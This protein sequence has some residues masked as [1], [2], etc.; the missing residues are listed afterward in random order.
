MSAAFQY[1]LKR[2]PF[3]RPLQSAGHRIGAKTHKRLKGDTYRVAPGAPWA[4]VQGLLSNLS[5]VM[6]PHTLNTTRRMCEL[7]CV[8]QLHFSHDSTGA[9]TN[10]EPVL[11]LIKGL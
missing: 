9:Q 5:P 1:T 4:S 6:S 2:R 7:E 11:Q 10:S 3:F 8:A